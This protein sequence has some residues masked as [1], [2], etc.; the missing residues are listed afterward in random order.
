MITQSDIIQLH[1]DGFNAARSAMLANFGVLIRN[2]AA[3]DVDI[4]E[5]TCALRQLLACLVPT[6][7]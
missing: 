3:S 1:R 5:T 6:G 7:E 2:C 4:E